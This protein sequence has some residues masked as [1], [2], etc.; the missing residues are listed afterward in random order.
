MAASE[1][2]SAFERV[3]QLVILAVATLVL[4]AIQPVFVKWVVNPFDPQTADDKELQ[5]VHAFIGVDNRPK[6]SLELGYE[7]IDRITKNREL[8]RKESCLYQKDNEKFEDFKDFENLH[9]PPSYGTLGLIRQTTG[10]ALKRIDFLVTQQMESQ[11]QDDLEKYTKNLLIAL[12]IANGNTVIRHEFAGIE[13]DVE[14]LRSLFEKVATKSA[15]DLK[16]RLA[17][18]TTGGT[19]LHTLAAA[20]ASDRTEALIVYN[21]A[22]VDRDRERCPSLQLVEV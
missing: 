19:A 6:G 14:G 9:F 20:K 15:K 21:N 11:E 10:Q 18:D 17:I 16:G 7:Q 22:R 3:P 12:E 13:I 5:K 1:V 2:V 8:F 4:T